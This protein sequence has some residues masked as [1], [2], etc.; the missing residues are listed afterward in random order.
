MNRLRASVAADDALYLAGHVRER[1]VNL[2]LA[3][4]RALHRVPEHVLDL[5]IAR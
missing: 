2:Q 5:W 1:V 4:Y 3:D